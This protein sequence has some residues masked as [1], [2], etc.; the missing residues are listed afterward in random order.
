MFT[1]PFIQWLSA[2]VFSG[3][4]QLERGANPL[5]SYTADRGTFAL[6]QSKLLFSRLHIYSHH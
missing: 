6:D 2:S 3:V 1:Q 5:P 4:K